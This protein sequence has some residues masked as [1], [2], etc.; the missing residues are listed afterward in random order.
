[1]LEH[2][3][4]LLAISIFLLFFGV[5]MPFLMVIKVV[6]STLFLNFLSFAASVVGL[7]LGVIGVAIYR[8]KQ[9]RRSDE[10]NRYR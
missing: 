9:T 7:F 3:R 10:E 8:A 5:A 6:E 1:M 2:P 4:L